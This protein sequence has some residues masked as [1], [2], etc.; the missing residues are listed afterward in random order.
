MS[1]CI[2]NFNFLRY[3]LHISFV[4]CRDGEMLCTRV[5][6]LVDTEICDCIFLRSFSLSLVLGKLIIFLVASQGKRKIQCIAV[7]GIMFS[8]GSHHFVI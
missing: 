7:Y 5:F 6:M 8:A 2:F 3:M 4:C 1:I